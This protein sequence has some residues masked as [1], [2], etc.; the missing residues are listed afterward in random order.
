MPKRLEFSS[1]LFSVILISGCLQRP[2][3]FRP[4]ISNGEKLVLEFLK[5]IND[6]D[7]QTVSRCFGPEIFQSC[8]DVGSRYKKDALLKHYKEIF[9]NPAPISIQYSKIDHNSNNTEFIIS[10]EGQWA[11]IRIQDQDWLITLEND[12]I[13]KI[14]Q[15]MFRH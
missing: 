1:V 9:D 10:I 13:V 8:W 14:Q 5:A 2:D 15:C 12:K 6:R 4:G 7:I 11:N 3:P